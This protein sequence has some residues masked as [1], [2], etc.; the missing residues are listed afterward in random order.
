MALIDGQQLNVLNEWE[1]EDYRIEG[2]VAELPIPGTS[3]FVFNNIRKQAPPSSE[4]ST[5]TA[6]PWAFMQTRT[7]SSPRPR[8]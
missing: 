3:S 8:P 5:T 7:D 4:S 6:P 1:R 2:I